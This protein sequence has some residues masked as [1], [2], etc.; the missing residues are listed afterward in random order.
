M[1]CALL[2]EHSGVARHL[3]AGEQLDVARRG[4]GGDQG[5]AMVLVA[6]R[7]LRPVLAELVAR[8][9]LGAEAGLDVEFD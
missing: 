7:V 3:E 5:Q 6:G 9:L 8:G 2:G 1:G 4:A